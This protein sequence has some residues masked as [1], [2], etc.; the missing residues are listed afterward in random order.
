MKLEIQETKY[1]GMK[2]TGQYLNTYS[3]TKNI[4]EPNL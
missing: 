4:Y 1:L 3:G 2:Y